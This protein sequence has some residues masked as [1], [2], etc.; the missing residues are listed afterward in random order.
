IATLQP[1]LDKQPRL[2]DQVQFWLGK[3][4]AGAAAAITDPAKAADRDNGLK[5]AVNTIRAAADK[6]NALSASDP[7]AKTR[8]AEMLLE[9]ADTQQLAK[10]YKEAASTYEQ[11]LNE[12]SLP[13]RTEEVTQRL[14]AALHLA[15]E[16]ARS[17]QVAN[18]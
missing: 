15:G 3:A 14:I 1:M 12:K 7:D 18:Q 2:A 8:R 6:A 10:Q 5:N 17:D 16:Y 13:A 4:Q 11:I 9:A